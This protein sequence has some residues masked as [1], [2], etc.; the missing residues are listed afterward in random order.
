MQ[1]VLLYYANRNPQ[2]FLIKRDSL[3]LP[4]KR[5]LDVTFVRWLPSWLVVV[6]GTRNMMG[7][8][9]YL[10]G[11]TVPSIPTDGSMLAVLCGER[12]SLKT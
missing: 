9:T 8:A 10:L 5:L 3:T 4:P 2:I 12:A 1:T 6:L 7:V 11:F